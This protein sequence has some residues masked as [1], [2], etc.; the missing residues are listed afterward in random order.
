MKC[1][2]WL[3]VGVV[4]A[5]FLCGCYTPASRIKKHPE[6]FDPLPPEIKAKVQLGEIEPGY[7][8]NMVFL[9]KGRPD[10][11][12][13]RVTNK[14]QTIIWSY[15]RTERRRDRE[16]VSVP[17]RTRRDDGRYHTSHKRVWVDVDHEREYESERV[18]FRDNKVVAIETIE[19]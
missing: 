19:W 11:K 10:R 6:I 17:V 14:R 7:T 18:E 13:R 16:R 4:F 8:T 2:W 1:T 9:A 5:G 3:W 15:V 12:Y